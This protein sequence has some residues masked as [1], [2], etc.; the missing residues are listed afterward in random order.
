VT[1]IEKAINALEVTDAAV[2]RMRYF[3]KSGINDIAKYLCITR[4][5]VDK[6]INK[7]VERMSF[8][9]SYGA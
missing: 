8:C 9:I 6:R 7:I 3:D 4:Q 1:A 5:A 2:I